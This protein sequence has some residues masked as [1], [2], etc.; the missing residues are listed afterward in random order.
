MIEIQGVT[1][2][3]GETIAVRDAS[4]RL[5][6]GRI[7]AIV[8]ENG[9]GKSTL[10]KIAA[11]IVA[12]DSGHVSVSGKQLAPHTAAMGIRA[13]VGMVAQ[14]FSLVPVFTA[15]DNVLLGFEPLTGML[16]FLDR[17]AAR[18]RAK[19]VLEDLEATVDLDAI[20]SELGVGDRQR[21]EIVRVLFRDA[22]YL[23]LDEPTA[24]LAPQEADAL[25]TML[26]RMAAAGRAVAVV[27]HKLDEV[28][29]HA[30]RVTV[31]RR[32]QIVATHDVDAS[33][34]RADLVRELTREVM[35]GEPPAPVGRTAHAP[36]GDVLVADAL[37]VAPHLRG[38]T[39]RVRAG[40]IVGVCG[41]EGSGQE[42]LVRA[43]AGL[44]VPS[45]GEVR[46]PGSSE[47]PAIV[48]ADR[49]REG[50]V[51]E[52][53]VLDNLLLGELGTFSGRV[54]LDEHRERA[55]ATAR[56][57]RGGIVPPNADLPARA[58]S[59]GNQ[60]KIVVE[61]ACSRADGKKVRVLV[62]AHPTRGVDVGAARTIQ[63]RIAE[64]AARGVGVLVLGSDLDELRSL[65]DRL[66][67]M[68]RG[69]IAGEVPRDASAQR[70]GEMMLGGA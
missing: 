17:D 46:M 31:M 16:G 61:R 19:R 66:L 57:E 59:G 30:N 14:H 45:A 67:V 23:I 33:K 37:V 47:R 38:A 6:P 41:I 51:L 68:A 12:P 43:I 32:G 49:H 69:R 70:I 62:V 22:Q 15:L 42:E 24:I 64:V 53:S 52:A 2:R 9:A 56:I 13:G 40:E 48:F 36:G 11:G 25:Y 7:H 8:G 65:S 39:L 55:E 34:P 3:Y 10:L 1:K 44:V 58:L 4:L 35:G 27:T 50:L 18:V 26:R 5:E 20:T 21:L 28:H 29:A 63:N 60:Q 54:L